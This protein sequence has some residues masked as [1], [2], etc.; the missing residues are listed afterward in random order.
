MLLRNFSPSPLIFFPFLRLL[1][2]PFVM[3]GIASLFFSR[4]IVLATLMMYSMPCGL[5]TIIFPKLIGEDCEIGASLALLSNVL[6]IVTI[7]LGVAVFL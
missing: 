3:A 2:I 4:E 5:N 6:A 7:P 1:V